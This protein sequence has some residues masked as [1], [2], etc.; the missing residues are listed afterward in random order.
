MESR[1]P[2][3]I[4]IVNDYDVVVQGLAR[5]FEPMKDRIQVVEVSTNRPGV[6]PVDIALIDSFAQTRD[7]NQVLAEANAEH[8]VFYSWSLAPDLIET[9]AGFGVVGFLDKRLTAEELADALERIKRGEAGVVS[10]DYPPSADIDLG[11]WPG[12]DHGLTARE[13]EVIA[14]I[15]QGLGNDEI[16]RRMFTSINTVKTYIRSAYRKIDV[17]TRTRAVLWGVD[18]GFRPDAIKAAA[19]DA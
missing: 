7:I 10:A 17:D 4:S 1:V 18:H 6:A 9:W 13:A 14:L 8:Y 12:R 5:M 15:T 3:R 11:D 19:P 16:A 2:V